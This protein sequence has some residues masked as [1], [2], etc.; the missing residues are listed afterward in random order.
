M[1]REW[2]CKYTADGG[3]GPAD[4]ASLKAAEALLQ[5][6]LPK[7]KALPAAKVTRVMCGGCQDFKIV[8]N[9]PCAEH[10]EWKAAAYAPE[11]EFI[12]KLAAIEG[13]SAVETQEYTCQPL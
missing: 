8:V 9:Q 10:D 12:A 3:G 2:R 1:A 6:Y 7:L 5:E 11:A 13:I 4:S